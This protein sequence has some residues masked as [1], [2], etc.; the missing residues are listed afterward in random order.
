MIENKRKNA[1][2]T[3]KFKIE[4]YQKKKWSL[5]PTITL[6]FTIQV[7][8]IKCI[9]YSERSSFLCFLLFIHFYWY[10]GFLSLSM[11]WIVHVVSFWQTYSVGRKFELRG[12][13]KNEINLWLIIKKDRSFGFVFKATLPQLIV[14]DTVFRF[15][16]CITW[17]VNMIIFH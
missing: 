8:E 16:P 14:V 6:F 15:E 1:E 7:D 4:P 17:D 3:Y 2:V 10:Q 12:Y 5:Y 9:L 11:F 13:Q